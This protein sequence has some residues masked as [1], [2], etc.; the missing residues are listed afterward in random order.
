MAQ[1]SKLSYFSFRCHLIYP[2]TLAHGHVI[3]VYGRLAHTRK[4][5][6]KCCRVFFTTGYFTPF[7]VS[8]RPCC[9]IGPWNG[10]HAVRTE[11]QRWCEMSHPSWVIIRHDSYPQGKEKFVRL[12]F[13]DLYN[14]YVGEWILIWYRNRYRPA[15]HSNKLSDQGPLYVST[16][17]PAWISNCIH[18]KVW[19]EIACPFLNFNDCTV[20]V[21]EQVI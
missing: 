9:F 8:V 19:D 11:T 16:F 14:S 6:T 2:F 21:C 17:I 3:Y 4:G 20:E 15:C 1:L 5:A 13:C 10:M 18:Y 7:A 12:S